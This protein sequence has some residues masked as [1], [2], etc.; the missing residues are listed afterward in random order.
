MGRENVLPKKLFGHLHPVKGIPARN[1]FFIGA[2]SLAALFLDLE[3]AL[4]FINFGALTAFTAVNASVIAHYYIRN[5]QRSLR[6]VIHY[7]LSPL[8]GTSFVA[9]LWYNLDS[10]ALTLG[11]TWS[12]VGISYLLFSTKFFTK[13]PPVIDFEEAC[14]ARPQINHR[15]ESTMKLRSIGKF[16]VPLCRH[17]H[18][19]RNNCGRQDICFRRKR[20]SYRI[21]RANS[22]FH[23]RASCLPLPERKPYRPNSP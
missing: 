8:I 17:D 20:T 18:C 2:S 19:R 23:L 9:F 5:Q 3:T 13:K 7:L 10:H 14:K 4:A 16:A 21:R 12:L 22:L 6:D 1:V 15:S 11:L